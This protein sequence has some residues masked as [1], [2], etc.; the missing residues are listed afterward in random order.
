MNERLLMLL[1]AVS[2]L[3]AVGVILYFARRRRQPSQLLLLGFVGIGFLLH[4][5]GLHYRGLE[6]QSCP[7]GNP[8]EVFQFISWSIML[9]YLLTGPVFRMTILG[10][11]SA[12]LAG[13]IGILSSLV[14]SWD[15]GTRSGYFGGNPWIETHAATS[16]FTYGVFG[17]L[18]VTCILYLIQNSSLR[19][20]KSG[21]FSRF[22][23]SILQLDSVNFRL[24]IIGCVFFTFSLTIGS[25]YWIRNIE[26]VAWFKLGTTTAIWIAYLGLLGLRLTRTLHGTRMAWAGVILFVLALLALWPVESNRTPQ[27][28]NSDNHA[29]ISPWQ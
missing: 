26:S 6:R 9:V 25:V 29:L 18:A 3:F 2:Y 10:G 17:L 21:T 20:K 22:L 11:F 23:P 14:P 27:D 13:L 15:S 5:I 28:K 1:G 24:L 8:Y 16:I 4:S 7:I 19:S 12:G